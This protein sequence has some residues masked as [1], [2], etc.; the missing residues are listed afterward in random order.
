MGTVVGC[1][2][3]QQ[4]KSAY[5]VKHSYL[6]LVLSTPGLHDDHMILIEMGVVTVMIHY[7]HEEQHFVPVAMVARS[8][9]TAGGG[10]V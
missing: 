9:T 7:I 1:F 10:D 2:K 4:E 6:S 3:F 8:S 5:T